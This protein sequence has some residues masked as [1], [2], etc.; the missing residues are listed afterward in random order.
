MQI[1]MVQVMFSF[2]QVL[3]LENLQQLFQ[4]RLLSL[5]TNAI[6]KFSLTMIP[7]IQ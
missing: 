1:T 5:K 3:N 4:S 2:L 7:Q 6:N